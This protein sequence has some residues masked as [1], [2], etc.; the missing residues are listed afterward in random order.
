MLAFAVFSGIFLKV[1]QKILLGVID[2][3]DREGKSSRFIIEKNLF[4]L[5]EED[6]NAIVKFYH[7]FPYNYGP[8]S[9]LSFNDVLTLRSKKLLNENLADLP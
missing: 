6:V 4:L 7:F 9:Y 1:I 3:W 5:K 8:F 2:K